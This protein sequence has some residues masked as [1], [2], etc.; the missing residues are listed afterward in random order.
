MQTSATP[1]FVGSRIHFPHIIPDSIRNLCSLKLDPETSPGWRGGVVR[2]AVVGR[3]GW[4]G[5]SFLMYSVG[6][7]G[8][9]KW[10]FAKCCRNMSFRRLCK[11]V[12]VDN[13]ALGRPR[14]LDMPFPERFRA[15]CL[16]SVL[17][18]ASSGGFEYTYAILYCF[19]FDK[20]LWNIEDRLWLFTIV[21]NGDIHNKRWGDYSH[22]QPPFWRLGGRCST[23]LEA[24]R[25]HYTVAH[26]CKCS[27]LN[28]SKP[29]EYSVYVRRILV[30]VAVNYGSIRHRSEA[31]ASAGSSDTS[32][33]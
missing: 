20:V 33:D 31:T 30:A 15:A 6:R 29:W 11:G 5:G 19:S 17:R 8:W 1:S 12:S 27:R 25:W 23:S 10:N 13:V 7:T 24:S 9:A 14:C 2:G 22:C 28:R 21:G 18:D 26:K 16:D 32:T 4:W 3:A